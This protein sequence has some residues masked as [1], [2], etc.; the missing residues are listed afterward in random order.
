MNREQVLALKESAERVYAWMGQFSV[1][2]GLDPEVVHKANHAELRMSDVAL[3]G[4][5][6]ETCERPRSVHVC[7]SCSSDGLYPG[8]GCINCRQSGWNQSP[9]LP[10]ARAS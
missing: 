1:Q 9:C 3:P 5:P 6:C 2:R 4:I 8:S 7:L 10:P